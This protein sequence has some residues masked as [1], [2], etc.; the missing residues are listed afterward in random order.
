MNT[1]LYCPNRQEG[2]WR[3][4]VQKTRRVYTG[5]L[6]MAS[7]NGFEHEVAWWDAVDVI[8]VDA[9]YKI[10]GATEAQLVAAWQPVGQ[11]LA[12]LSA[13]EGKKVAF[14]EIGMCSGQ[15][16][17]THTPSLADYDWHARQYA[18]VFHAL[19]GHSDWFLGSF[20][21]NWDTDPGAFDRDDCLTPQGKPAEEVLRR[22]YR[23][24]GPMPAFVGVGQCVGRGR[25]TC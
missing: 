25:C 2:H 16:S 9:Y 7:I 8:G 22:F 20:W 1:E 12:S 13:R 14:T 18:A 5:Q 4:L 15:C 10:G 11:S 3:E 17:R 19:Q 6:T 23:A 21:W 24:P